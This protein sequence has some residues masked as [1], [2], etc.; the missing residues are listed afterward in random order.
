MNTA[1]AATPLSLSTYMA[2]AYTSI[3]NKLLQVLQVRSTT[4]L[5][6]FRG[7]CTGRTYSVR[8]SVHRPPCMEISPQKDQKLF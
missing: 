2:R 7:Q 6:A 5:S 1:T 3:R 8:E 4:G